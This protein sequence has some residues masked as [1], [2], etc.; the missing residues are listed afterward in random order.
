MTRNKTKNTR[1]Q[2][3]KKRD[4]TLQSL[5]VTLQEDVKEYLNVSLGILKDFCLH[6]LVFIKF[7]ISIFDWSFP[8]FLFFPAAA[9]S[10]KSVT[11]WSGNQGAGLQV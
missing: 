2:G 3:E 4:M 11:L 8:I 10:N 9:I 5:A 1:V 7:N 6:V